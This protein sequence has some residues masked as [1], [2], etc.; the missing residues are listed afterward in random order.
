MLQRPLL[1]LRR[2]LPLLLALHLLLLHCG[3]CWHEARCRCLLLLSLLLPCAALNTRQWASSRSAS[4]ASGRSGGGAARLLL[5][6]VRLGHHAAAGVQRHVTLLGRIAACS[7]LHSHQAADGCHGAA[8]HTRLLLALLLAARLSSRCQCAA[9]PE[10]WAIAGC[11]R[12]GA[13]PRG[14]WLH[15]LAITRC[16]CGCTWWQLWG[17]LLLLPCALAARQLLR[18]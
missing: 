6:Q 10:R 4:I 18:M 1:L 12:A 13:P 2:R 7:L 14:R 5:L 9:R 16:C 8:R 15:R 17:R 3:A 11:W